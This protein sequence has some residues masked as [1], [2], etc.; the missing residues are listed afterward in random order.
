[1]FYE[2]RILNRDGKVKKVFSRHE[3]SKNYWK[4]FQY[5]RRNNQ[6]SFPFG[7]KVRG[8]TKKRKRGIFCKS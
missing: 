1:M 7:N 3:L 8:S 4:S 5:D 2:V 6:H